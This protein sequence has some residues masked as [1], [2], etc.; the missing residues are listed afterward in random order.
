MVL[1][2]CNENLFMY[3]LF[4]RIKYYSVITPVGHMLAKAQ[5]H[6]CALGIWNPTQYG[7]GS[8]PSL[9]SDGLWPYKW[10]LEN[11]G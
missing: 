8:G 1:E 3:L 6:I 7:M 10:I 4:S 11:S 9:P 2:V 5:V